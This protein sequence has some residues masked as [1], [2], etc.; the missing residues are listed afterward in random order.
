MNSDL[1]CGCIWRVSQP[2]FWG[3][4]FMSTIPT[5]YACFLR[6]WQPSLCS[7]SSHWS[8]LGFIFDL[9]IW[10]VP[11]HLD[12][13][14]NVHAVHKEHQLNNHSCQVIVKL[15]AL[16]HQSKNKIIIMEK[17]ATSSVFLHSYNICKN[18]YSSERLKLSVA[19]KASFSIINII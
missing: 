8:L 2:A 9:E 4:H 13:S 16:G 19:Q 7:T 15:W 10:V 3:V 14:I 6:T 12:N 1:H 18:I 17:L 5:D 11:V